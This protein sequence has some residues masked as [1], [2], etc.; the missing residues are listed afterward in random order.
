MGATTFY[1]YA[2]RSS[3]PSGTNSRVEGRNII[4]STTYSDWPD[5]K[6]AFDRLA[7]ED[8]YDNGH[9]YSG[10]IGMKH[11]FVHIATVD[12]HAEALMLADN[13]IA[14]DDDRICDKWGP[15]GCITIREGAVQ[16]LFF[17]WASS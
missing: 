7:D 9:Q 2:K 14:E 17:G 4:T 13:L 11:N 16:F 15:A 12:T 10:G 5:A 8:R 1:D 6:I 3:Y